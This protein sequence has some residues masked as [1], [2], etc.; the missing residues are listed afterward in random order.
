MILPDVRGRACFR[1]EDGGMLST[2]AE[3]FRDC[4][5]YGTGFSAEEKYSILRQKR[6][7]FLSLRGESR[8]L[9]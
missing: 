5:D 9:K 6:R 1:M 4:K 7:G 2:S 3:N 8:S